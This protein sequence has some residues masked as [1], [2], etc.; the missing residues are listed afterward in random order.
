[1]FHDPRAKAGKTHLNDSISG[2]KRDQNGPFAVKSLAAAGLLFADDCPLR[3]ARVFC[4]HCDGLSKGSLRDAID[5]EEFDGD[6]ISLLSNSRNFVRLN[7]KVRWEKT[8]YRRINKSDYADRAVLEALVN[9]LMHREWFVIGSEVH[10]DM[11]DDRLDIY[12]PGGMFDGAL[13]RLR[14]G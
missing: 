14:K 6:I 4:A 5:S 2:K 3:Q 13:I 10:V 11:Y 8:P 1:M 12:S 9:N 7:S